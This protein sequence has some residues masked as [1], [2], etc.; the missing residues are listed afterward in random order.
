MRPFLC[1]VFFVPTA[2]AAPREVTVVKPVEREVIDYE[3][4]TGRTAASVTVEIRARVT[5]YLEKVLFKEGSLVKKGDMLLQLDDRLQQAELAKAQA[6]MARAEAGLKRVE[7]DHERLI[8]LLPQKVISQEEVDRSRV[9]LDEAKA[10][11]QVARAVVDIAKLNLAYMRIISPIDGRIGRV[12]VDA[13]NLVREGDGLTTIVVVEPL[14]V[15]FDFDERNAL[16][17]VR[18]MQ[19]RK[20]NRL[21]VGVK[22]GDD[23]DYPRAATI[24]FVDPVVDAKSGTLHI[25]AVLPNPKDEM[26]PGQFVRVRVPLSEPRKALL[27]PRGAIPPSER[28]VLVVNDKNILED[29]VVKFGP[30]F[31]GTREV[32][33]GLKATDRVVDLEASPKGLQAGDEVRAK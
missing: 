11:V 18:Y 6:E 3:F 9:A 32:V 26:R 30:R 10:Q 14:H 15:V 20:D 29:R 28:V 24:D 7:T 13:G 22:L 31:D 19:T 12:L 16:Q 23:E 25:R 8:K 2:I 21:A 33:S 1:L 4:V 5:G 27:V 17:L